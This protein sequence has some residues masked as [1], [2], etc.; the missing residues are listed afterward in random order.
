MKK[1]LLLSLLF[2][3]LLALAAL[4]LYRHFENDEPGYLHQKEV[5]GSDMYIFE[6]VEGPLCTSTLPP[7]VRASWKEYLGDNVSALAILLTDSTGNWLGLVHGL[8]NIGVPFII[9]D[10]ASEAV[11]HS[12]VL[13]YP[14]ISGK[15][16]F[17]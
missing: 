14:V 17:R 3:V 10:R 4:W 7:E 12:T 2:S 13:V 1:S 16:R 6:G 8:K 11:K 5:K 15:V 9:T